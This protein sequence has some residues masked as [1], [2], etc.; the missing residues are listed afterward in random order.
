MN[1][2]QSL[3][4]EKTLEFIAYCEST[5]LV[6]AV[7]QK[8]TLRVCMFPQGKTVDGVQVFQIRDRSGEYFQ[9]VNSL[10]GKPPYEGDTYGPQRSFKT[11]DE[12]LQV[13]IPFRRN[14]RALKSPS[15]RLD[16]LFKKV[17]KHHWTCSKL[18]ITAA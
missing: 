17:S 9:M 1:Q 8:Q 6:Q 16:G 15:V 7:E 12:Y 11:G 18:Q 3:V 2:A 4:N 5:P 10:P 13:F 14:A